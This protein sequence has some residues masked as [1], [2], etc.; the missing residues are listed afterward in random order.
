[1]KTNKIYPGLLNL[2]VRFM[3][4]ASM[5]LGMVANVGTVFAAPSLSLQSVAVSLQSGTPTYGTAGS[6]TFT[7]TVTRSSGTPNTVTMSISGLPAGATGTFGAPSAWSPASGTGS[8][9]YQLTINTT[10]ALAA[11][12]YA[13][14][15]QASGTGPDPIGSGTLTIA[16]ANQ[17]ITFGALSNKTEGDPDFSVSATASSGLTVSFSASGS[18]T[19]SGTLVHLTGFGSCTLT[20]SQAGNANYNAAQS[21]QQ[22]FTI[23]P[24]GPVTSLDLYAMT[25]S[26][27]LPGGASVTVW[28]YSSTSSGP[29]TQPGGPVLDVDQGE[30]VSITLHNVDIPENTA[31]LFLGQSMIPDL[32]GVGAGGSK[33]YTFV[34]SQAGTFLYEAGLID[35]SQH[36]VAMGMYGALVVR[37]ATAGQAYD[38]ASTA[39]DE[40]LVLVLSEIDPSLNNSANPAAFDMR[41]YHPRYW[42]INGKSYPQTDPV[43][44]AAGHK[45]LLRYINAGIQVHSMSV[46]GARQG[47]IAIDGNPLN[48]AHSLVA[49]SIG[50]GRGM[51]TIV[52]IPASAGDGSKFTVYEASFLQ[53]NNNA[54]GFGGM[55]TFLNVSGTP[56]TGDTTGPATSGVSLTTTSVSATISDAGRGDSDVTAAEFFIDAT[57]A[58]GSGTAMDPF[59]PAITVN[60]SG[61]IAPALSGTHTVYVHGQDSAGNWGPFQSAV[62]TNDTTGPTTSALTLSPASTNGTVNVSLSGTADDTAS[63]G[64]NI[65]AAEYTIDGGTATAVNVSPS[66][67]KVAS[68]SATLPA[69]TIDAL[70]VGAHVIAVRSQDSLGNWGAIATITLTVDKTGPAT[71][72]VTAFP[73]PTNG[74][75]GFNSNTPAV[76]VTANLTDAGTVSNIAA[77]EGFI[78]TVGAT[79]TGIPFL[80]TDGIFNSPSETGY[81][82]IPLTTIRNLSDGNHTLYIHAKDAAGNWGTTTSITLTIDKTAPVITGV[83]LV[84]GTIAIGAASVTLN[85]TAN[86]GTGVGIGSGQYW[87]DGTST[88]PA[89]A[90]GF[91]GTSTSIDTSALTGGVHTVY[92][93]VQDLVG[94]WSTVS[95]ASLIVIQAVDD[96]RTITANGSATQTSDANA[97]AGV[98]A[99]DEPIGNAGRTVVLTSAPTR[100]SG[101]GAGTI[102]LSCPASLGTAATPSVGGNTI[103]TNG[104]YRVTLNGVG[105]NNN[106]RAASKRGSFQ[107]TYTMTLNGVTQTA[108]VT[109]VV[110]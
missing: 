21:V 27:S 92:V 8:R 110:Q 85:V 107:F 60:V 25:G 65:A 51:D 30:V 78:D 88:P 43:S 32:T 46:L 58:S 89:G 49:E 2:G 39:F 13:F 75:V 52:T 99:N 68:L 10:A 73:N 48:Y 36:Q 97:A 11:G 105:N 28:G 62:I 93:R 66:G 41:N 6:A 24:A 84:P 108:T 109:I 5:L 67:A 33:T 14:N 34:A 7:V 101:T 37:P 104:A 9:T 91:A 31:L 100:T 61:T 80:P 54:A 83:T 35:N 63:G 94:N 59:T 12:S 44:T 15:V 42:L 3:I 90:T 96:S 76:R 57:S 95:S 26:T 53:H 87:I 20:A 86:D 70:S 19:V 40:E 71:S 82:D 74:L 23:N 1:M 77:A 98:L 64:S 81:A 16:K 47:M 4:L 103:C 55:F 45:V 102:T 72:N 18:C 17:T 22:S 38:S 29:L 69:A 106:Q 79:G 50:P 56:T